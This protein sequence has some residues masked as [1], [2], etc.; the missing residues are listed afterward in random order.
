MYRREN[1]K[2]CLGIF[3][4]YII[5]YIYRKIEFLMLLGIREKK[6]E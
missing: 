4:I 1:F 5:I 3:I 6:I 2:K